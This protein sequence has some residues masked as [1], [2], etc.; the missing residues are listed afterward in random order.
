[1]RSVT[2]VDAGTGGRRLDPPQADAKAIVQALGGACCYASMASLATLAYQDGAD[3]FAVVAARSL[4]A[5]V[6]GLALI[7]LLRIRLPENPKDWL[8][9]A[10]LGVLIF[11]Y[12]LAYMASVRFIPAGL[13]TLLFF[14]WP[15]FVAL[16]SLVL[17][18]QRRAGPLELAAF[19]LAFLGLV[20]AIGPGLGSLDPRGLALVIS[21]AIGIAVFI[22]ISSGIARRLAGP[23]VV[24]GGNIMSLLG[25]VVVGSALGGLDLPGT[26]QGRYV[27]LGIALCFA[28]GLLLQLGAIVRG[29]AANISIFANL[30]PLIAMGISAWMLGERLAPAQYGGGLLVVAALALSA[31]A[32]RPVRNDD[33]SS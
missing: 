4:G 8:K 18:R 10:A 20:L 6:L 11:L 16:A 17:H 32:R 22:L 30:E 1:M 12:S 13:A 15:I 33:V 28:L 2:G 3:P 23:V 27:M 5:V 7:A 9:L 24:V 19:P 14:L 25:A 26:E 21:A 29:G 31:W